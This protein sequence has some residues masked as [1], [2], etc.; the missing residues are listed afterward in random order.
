MMAGLSLSAFL[1]TLALQPVI[2]AYG[3]TGGYLFL[4][5]LAL[6]IGVPT[7]IFGT[8]GERALREAAG[9]VI[10]ASRAPLATLMTN[11]VFVLLTGAMFAVN[12]PASGVITQLRPLIG[13]KVT[14]NPGF[15]VA[16]YALSVLAG[17]VIVG[18]ALDRFES[19]VVAAS[20]AVF[21]AI[22]CLLLLEAVPGSSAPLAL[23]MIGLL[24]GAEADVLSYL[25]TRH[26]PQSAYGT[27]YGLLVTVSLLGTAAGIY[28]FGALYDATQSYDAA[29]LVA[30]GVLTAAM[31]IYWQMPEGTARRTLATEPG[32]TA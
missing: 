9:E 17:R 31:L 27:V 12:L 32:G 15:Y 4:A 22:G 3:H 21:G 11:R 30:V 18:A 1:V 25:V 24:Q 14:G 20:S 16:V 5:V 2:A 13:A 8:R 23:L 7:A 29:L 10:S 6:G 28:L 19:R 26:F